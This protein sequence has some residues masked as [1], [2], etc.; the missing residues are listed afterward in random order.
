MPIGNGYPQTKTKQEYRT[1][2]QGQYPK[3]LNQNI[4]NYE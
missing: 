3:E 4:K 1:A 2:V